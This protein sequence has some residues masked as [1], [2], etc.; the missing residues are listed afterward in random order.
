MKYLP[1][2]V[3][4]WHGELQLILCLCISDITSKVT[5]QMRNA[6][7]HV[8]TRCSVLFIWP[9]LVIGNTAMTWKLLWMRWWNINYLRRSARLLLTTRL[10]I[11]RHLNRCFYVISCFTDIPKCQMFHNAI[12]VDHII[13]LSTIFALIVVRFE[14]D[15]FHC[16]ITRV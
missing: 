15:F 3:W 4:L 5:Y 14:S 1:A 12:S 11:N 13:I 2:T 10:T 16:V 8:K 9:L 7:R 6:M